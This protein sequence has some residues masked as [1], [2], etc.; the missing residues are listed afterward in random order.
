VAPLCVLRHQYLRLRAAKNN[1]VG[2]AL[3]CNGQTKVI[4]RALGPMLSQ[5]HVPNV[6]ADPFLEVHNANGG[7]IAS[8]DNWKDMQQ[9]KIQASGFAPPDD[10]ES[11]VII[12]RPSGNTTAIV[13]GV[14][15][16]IGNALVEVYQIP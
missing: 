5:F 1:C 3:N 14:N 12:N 4:I 2:N 9:A 6:L 16:S 7:V 10:N 15:N 11:A 13:K 8:N